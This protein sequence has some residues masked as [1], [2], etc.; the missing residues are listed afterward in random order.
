MIK[1]FGIEPLDDYLNR[2]REF[3]KNQFADKQGWQ[4][5]FD[6]K[7]LNGWK[8]LNQDWTNP[9]SKPDFYVEND[10]IVCNTVMGNEGGYLITEKSYSDFILELDVKIDTSLNSG[11]QCRGRIWEKDTSTIYV[12]GDLNLDKT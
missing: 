4:N 1:E 7:T 2:A 5:L 8:V 9:D 12:A 10:M 3:R 11:L 6:G